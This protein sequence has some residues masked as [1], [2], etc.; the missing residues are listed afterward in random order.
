MNDRANTPKRGYL[1]RGLLVVIALAGLGLV[2]VAGAGYRWFGD[3]RL[4]LLL[5]LIASLVLLFAH[6]WIS[7]Y[8]IGTSRLIAKT[9]TAHG[10]DPTEDTVRRRLVRRALPWL[11]GAAIAVVAAF[12]SG[13]FAMIRQ[14]EARPHFWHHAIFFAALA[15]QLPAI[16][17][18]RPGLA[19]T[20][21]RVRELDARIDRPS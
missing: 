17:A 21:R 5:A 7:I 6:S 10:F 1:G 13:A 11:V 14:G 15:L 4:H 19:E 16:L 20:E 12:L 3:Q 2:A 8:L 18:A 9:V